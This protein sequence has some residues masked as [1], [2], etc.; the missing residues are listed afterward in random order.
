MHRPLIFPFSGLI[1]GIIIGNFFD[2]PYIFLSVFLIFI[3]VLLLLSLRK[4]WWI[5]S[6]LLIFCFAAILG[7]FDIQKQQYSIR[8]DRHILQ[9]ASL[10]KKTIEGIVIESPLSYPDKNILIVRCIRLFNNDTYI[11]VAGNV[12]LVI[13]AHLNFSYGDF[14]RF[15]SSLKKIQSFKNPGGFDYE[16]YLNRQGI[17][18]TGFI[19]DTSGIIRLRENSAGYFKLRLESFRMY[20]KQLIYQNAPSPQREIIEAMTIGNQTAIPGDVKENFSKTGTSHILSISGLH[21]GM[22]AAMAFFCVSLLLKSSEYLLLKLNMIKVS[23]AAAFFLVLFYALIAG[24]GVTVLRSA[25]M[26]LIFL[27][28]LMSGRQRDFYN[29][30]ALA[31]LVILIIFP[32]ALFDISFQLSFLAVLAIIYIVPKLDYPPFYQFAGLPGWSQS[33]IRYF[34]MLLI[35]SLAATIGTLPLIIYYFNQISSVTFIA[36]LIAVPLLGTIALATAMLFLLTAF[37]SPLIAGFF[38]KITSFFVSISI[39]IINRLASLSFASFSITKPNI[40]E[41]IIFYIFVILLI[42]FIDIRRGVKGYFLQHTR[43]LKYGL[44]LIPVFFIVDASYLFFKDKLSS[45]LRVTAI[46]VGQGSSILVRFPGGKNMLIDGG[47]FAGSSFDTGKMIVASY[48]YHERISRID[49]VVLTHPHPDHMLGLLYILDNFD[50]QE[51]WTTEIISDDEDYQKLKKII[52]ERKIKTFFFP[53][54]LPA[55]KNM[56]NAE[57]NLMWPDSSGVS[58]NELSDNDINDLSL[59]F[60]I[61]YGRISFLVTGDISA[62]IENILVRSGRDL[63]SDVL[64]VP[65]HGSAYSSSGDFIKK[66]ACRYAVV[67]AGKNNTFHHPHPSTIERYTAAHVNVLRTDQDGAVSMITDGTKLSVKTFVEH[68]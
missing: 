34:Y 60:R 33:I 11:P 19:A 8:K 41:I 56:G 17:Y 13:P 39:E 29:T 65:H 24:M 53:K 21:V 45:D 2:F 49:T 44:I 68:R 58:T 50:V 30:L 64:F 47:G 52:K 28:A 14:I 48:L 55:R 62:E 15:Q 51:F 35:V 9:Y 32:E 46:D 25:L 43:Q 4:Q 54:D 36:N 22:V 7:I 16:H 67:S 38:V 20:L 1:I 18:A 3:L 23:A 63:K 31:G 59:V 10:G 61:R 66:V 57:I 42:Q 27:L 5:A 6:F 40:L 26:A 12:R 37:F